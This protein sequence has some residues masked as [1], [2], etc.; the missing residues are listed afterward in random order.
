MTQGLHLNLLGGLRVAVDGV[1]L[2]GLRYVKAEALLCYLAVTGRPHGRE[3]LADLLW[4]DMPEAAAR[5]NLRT[6]LSSLRADF[7]R[8]LVI[9]RRSVAFDPRGPY[10][11]DVERFLACAR[12]EDEGSWEGLERAVELYR[13]D[14]L[15]GFVVRDA[16]VFDEWLAGQRDRLRGVALQALH[17][18]AAHHAAQG[19]SAAAC[20]HLKRAIELEP[21]REDAHR[22]LMRVLARSGDRTAA[23]AHYDDLRR[24]LARDVGLE[25]SAETVALYE[26]LRAGHSETRRPSATGDAVEG[27]PVRHLPPETSPFVHREEK[28]E[29]ARRLGDPACRLL[30]LI[31][32][33]GTGKTRLASEVA[34]NL[35]GEF[36]HGGWFVSLAS[37]A[38]AEGL[39]PTVASALGLPGPATGDGIDDLLA[40][41]RG[42]RLLLVLDNLEHLREST[43]VLSRILREAPAV[44]LLATSIAPLNV[45]GEW[46]FPVGGMGHPRGGELQGLGEEELRRY[47]AVRLFLQSASRARP[48]VRFDRDDLRTIAHICASVGAV[49]LAIELA[50]ALVRT[51]S[52]AEISGEIARDPDVLVAPGDAPE[53]HRSTR[54]VFEYAWA[55]MTSEERDAL[56]RTAVFRGGFTLEAA[57]EVTGAQVRVISALL[58]RALLYRDATGRYWHHVLIKAF[59]AE[60]AAARAEGARERSDAHAAYYLAWLERQAVALEGRRQ[61]EALAAVDAEMPNVRVAW[62][63]AL[64]RGKAAWIDRAIRALEDTHTLQGRFREAEA[65][66]AAAAAT[67]TDADLVASRARVSQGKCLIF[68]GDYDRARARLHESL[69]AFR[70]RDSLGDEARALQHL[71]VA[72]YHE[73]AYAEAASHMRESLERYRRLGDRVGIADNLNNLGNIAEVLG[74]Y[75]EASR[76]HAQALK[77]RREIGDPR[78]VAV[79]LVNVGDVAFRAGRVE[80]AGAYYDESLALRRS[81]GDQGRLA[82]SLARVG[83]VAF[84]SGDVATAEAAYREALQLAVENHALPWTVQ[85]LLGMAAVLAQAGSEAEAIE[86]LDLVAHHPVTPTWYRTR[87][88]RLLDELAARLPARTVASAK[89]RAATRELL[90]SAEEILGRRPYV[91]AV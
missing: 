2:T 61:R 51:L 81:I 24:T 59:V 75:D 47:P 38:S 60:K 26:Q 5:A 45:Q 29:I 14:L 4:S 88:E 17:R 77:L 62:A 85:A 7:A 42:R 25:P 31:G 90:G 57:L 28:D 91:V 83:D 1:P 48:D 40:N 64:S 73:G 15:E 78:S 79:S 80:E 9:S 6:V 35:A 70:D 33:G 82:G 50:A 22:R 19:A 21:W 53:R 65:A 10:D 43:G 76:L 3:A 52:L 13:G 20:A 74:D 23:L 54:A 72:H 67:L 71:G 87:A 8:Y 39:A 63:W 84:A 11:L 32:P 18:L 30:T 44:K 36:E 69:A 41:L 46:T 16:P 58:D 89:A 34:R 86:V 49:P 55:L 27:G 66:F 37:V 12:D 56:L 68:L